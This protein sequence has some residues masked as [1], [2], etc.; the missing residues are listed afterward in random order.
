MKKDI[1][2][3]S[4]NTIENLDFFLR[5]SNIKIIT[6]GMSSKLIPPRFKP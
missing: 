1:K 6:I 5:S 3:L 2:T 4:K